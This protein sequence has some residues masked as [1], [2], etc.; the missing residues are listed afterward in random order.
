[1]SSNDIQ[2]D[3]SSFGSPDGGHNSGQLNQEKPAGQTSPAL[4]GAASA[5]LP[6]GTLPGELEPIRQHWEQR[7]RKYGLSPSASWVD[8]TMLHREGIILSSFIKEGERVLDAG[9]A[10]GYTT[11]Q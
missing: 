1:M 10:N 6:F 11:V 8:E 4:F 2:V 3:V 5:R 9:C 7:G